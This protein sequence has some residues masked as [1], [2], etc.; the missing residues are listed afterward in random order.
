VQARHIPGKHHAAGRCSLRSVRIV[1]LAVD[2]AAHSD[3]SVVILPYVRL[4]PLTAARC[5]WLLFPAA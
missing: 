5:K 4:L 3:A 1:L 2:T